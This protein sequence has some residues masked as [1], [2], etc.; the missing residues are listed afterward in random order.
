M[1]NDECLLRYGTLNNESLSVPSASLHTV[2]T[3]VFFYLSSPSSS[4]EALLLLLLLLL[5]F[6]GTVGR[7]GGGCAC[8]HCLDGC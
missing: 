4:T 3:I 7:D 5:L 1:P 2:I 8:V 6:I